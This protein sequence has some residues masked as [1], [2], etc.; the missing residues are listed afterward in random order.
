VKQ[1]VAAEK[2]LTIV[3]VPETADFAL[4]VRAAADTGTGERAANF[5]LALDP[6]TEVS[7]DVSVLVPGKKQ[8]NGTFVPRVVWD[9]SYTHTQMDVP[10]SAR[11][12]VD[13]FL[14]ELRK[15]N[16]TDRKSK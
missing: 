6:E 2:T 1:S 16:A 12:A 3:N 7:V 13:G 5:T 4:L 9:A 15:A 11:F 10:T 14:T 8:A